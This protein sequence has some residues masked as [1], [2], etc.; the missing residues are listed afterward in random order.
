MKREVT[1]QEILI[2]CNSADSPIM[3]GLNRCWWSYPPNACEVCWLAPGGSMA[4]VFTWGNHGI[5]RHVWCLWGLLWGNHGLDLE[6]SCFVS[7]FSRTATCRE[8]GN[9]CG[10][11]WT[12]PVVHTQ[13]WTWSLIWIYGPWVAYQLL[14]EI[15]DTLQEK[16][17]CP[18]SRNGLKCGLP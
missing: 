6:R 10:W 12:L 15:D 8:S 5:Y 18:V 4:W 9:G 16:S 1:N 13:T 14:G 3:S 17:I 7:E 2:G 11:W